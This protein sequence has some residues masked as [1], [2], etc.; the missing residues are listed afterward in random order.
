MREKRQRHAG[1]TRNTPR[2]DIDA[3]RRRVGDKAFAR[4][5]AY[6][7]DDRVDLLSVEPN[8][9]LAQVEG[10]EDYQV[11]LHG[12][13][14]TFDGECSCPAFEDWGTCKH[15]V[16]VALAVNESGDDDSAGAVSRIRDHLMKKKVD[17]L[18]EM[19]IRIATQKPDFF[20]E[21][22]LEATAASPVGGKEIEA[23][24]KKVIDKATYIREY[25]DYRAALR[26]AAGVSAALDA[27]AKLVRGEQAAIALKLAEHAINQIGEAFEAVDDSDGHWGAL[28]EQAR[29]I[30]LAAARAVKPDPVRFAGELFARE[31][32][33]QYETFRG[34]AEIY[35]DVLGKIGRAEY[36][37]LAT[38]A[39]DELP[40]RSSKKRGRS[41][42]EGSYGTLLDILDAFAKRDGDVQARISLREKDLSSQWNYLTLVKFCVENGRTEEALRRAEEGLW[43]FEDE[44]PDER[45]VV[46]ACDLLQKAGRKDDLQALLWRTF[47]KAPTLDLYKRL[48]KSGGVPAREHAMA[49]LVAQAD[50]GRSPGFWRP[51]NLL[52]DILAHERDFD[53]AWSA[54]RKYGASTDREDEIARMSER[55]HPQEAL[56]VYV[57]RVEA[58]VNVGGNLAYERAAKLVRRMVSLRGA[59]EQAA[60]VAGLRQRFERRRNFIKLLG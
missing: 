30:H 58:L 53:A 22:D 23:S 29:D 50:G 34:A 17:A 14:K 10:S 8:R 42:R 3:L 45:L 49:F 60:Y 28:M 33:G 24:L 26:W 54:I 38:A 48:I 21:L 15:M 7:H 43:V 2:F 13:G 19:I 4:G 9:V 57:K 16:A 6:H 40:A 39:W 37:R 20:R 51:A 55:T 47:E 59:G 1:K 35:K 27:V 5:E 36:R 32:E 46:L 31:T 56:A 25:I 44:N 18:V 52:V 11:E 12:R 41:D